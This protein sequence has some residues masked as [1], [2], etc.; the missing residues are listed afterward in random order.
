[1]VSNGSGGASFVVIS[2]GPVNTTV[3]RRS[4]F[5]DRVS[6]GGLLFWW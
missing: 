3:L 4:S 5:P 6:A 1:M 2:E